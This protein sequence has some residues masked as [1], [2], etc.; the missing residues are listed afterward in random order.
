[1]KKEQDEKLNSLFKNYI[2]EEESPDESV[3]DKAME[4]MS[5]AEREKVPLSV[6]AGAEG[7]SSSSRGDG[8]KYSL[9]ITAGVLLIL[10]ALLVYVFSSSN[11]LS[12]LTS[13]PA[14]TVAR[15]QLSEA[16]LDLS[17]PT[18]GKSLFPFISEETI[19]SCKEYSLKEEVADYSAGEAV[20]YYVEYT[21]EGK[22]V[23]LYAEADGIYSDELSAYK[24][25]EQAQ[26]HS[27]TIFYY[28]TDEEANVSYVYF[29][30]ESFGYNMQLS[31]AD[32]TVLEKI[33]SDI[34]E[35]I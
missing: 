25:Y 15:E 21:A 33:L 26:L 31:T 9:I 24:E 18:A 32:K 11:R 5:S 14:Q 12:D 13:A 22:D 34:A 35:K 16:P 7:T 6:T 19:K 30:G 1:M 28:E 2:S 23:R 29:K 10:C 3:T 27:E 4:F 17:S 20:I 8:R